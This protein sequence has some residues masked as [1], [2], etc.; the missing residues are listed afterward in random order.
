[1]RSDD[2]VPRGDVVEREVGVVDRGEPGAVRQHP[3][4]RDRALALL[5]EL[6]PV[7]RDGRVRVEEP[8]FDQLVRCDRGD[9]LRAR[10]HDDDGVAFPRP[11]V[12]AVCETSP[13]VDDRLA[14][15][16]HAARGSDV[17]VLG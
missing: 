7:L 1:M 16:V 9:A 17:A 10:E 12:V 5:R 11:R 14:V 15:A 3:C 2:G 6:G 4:H 8:S 13:H